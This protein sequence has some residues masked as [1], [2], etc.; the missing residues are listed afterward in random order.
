MRNVS[1]KAEGGARFG[2]NGEMHILGGAFV[3]DGAFNKEIR[4]ACK[5]SDQIAIEAVVATSRIPQFGPARIISLSRSPSK[6]NFTLGQENDRLV[7]RLQTSN[8]NRNGMDFTL[9]PIAAGT[10]YHVLV[11][12]KPGLLVCY[13]N[14]KI[15]S[16]T[17]FEKGSFDKWHGSSYSLIFGNEVGGVRPWEGYLDGVAI[18]DRF[19]DAEEAA[20]KFELARARIAKRPR[21]DRKIVKAEML[22]KADSPPPEA[23]TPYRRALVINRY[24]IKEAND[25]TFVNQTVQ[26][27]E[28]ALLDAKV[29]ASYEHAKPGKISRAES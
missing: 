25:S 2:P 14:G 9:A 26:V 17:K 7:L 27:A 20:K 18:Y 3:P 13:L 6:R 23:I 22:Q 21:I 5:K 19:I 1:L 11:T 16:Q 4:D 15:A 29:P 28:W 12:Y 10:P 24:K 8:T